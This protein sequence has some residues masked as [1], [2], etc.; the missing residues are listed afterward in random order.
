MTLQN[1]VINLSTLAN[2][3]MERKTLCC[4]LVSPKGYERVMSVGLKSAHFLE[5]KHQVIFDVIHSLGSKGL[6]IDISI[7]SDEL[8]RQNHERLFAGVHTDKISKDAHFP[9]LA[10]LSNEVA[11]AAYAEQ[12]AKVVKDDGIRR[13]L[14]NYWS[15]IYSA[16][17][18]SKSPSEIIAEGI[19]FL[20][21]AQDITARTE[22]YTMPELV[23]Y[24]KEYIIQQE[25][26]QK[27]GR[28]IT[29]GISLLDNIIGG[30]KPG[31]MIV[32]A[33]PSVGKTDLGLNFA[34]NI[35][36]RGNPVGFISA[37]MSKGEMMSRVW[38]LSLKINRLKLF[39]ATMDKHE[40]DEV[41]ADKSVSKLPIYWDFSSRPTAHT[42]RA[43]LSAMKSNYGVRV[44][45]IDH[46]QMMGWHTRHR[47]S[48]ENW[49]EIPVAL[50]EVGRDLD[51]PI[52]LLAQ[53]S[54]GIEYEKRRPRMSDLREAGEEPVD[55]CLM[56]WR[57]HYQSDDPPDV[58]EM[59]IYAVKSR[60]GKTGVVKC[61]HDMATG[62]IGQA[63]DQSR[64]PEPDEEDSPKRKYKSKQTNRVD[65]G[66]GEEDENL[67]F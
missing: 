33:R 15:V 24:S 40:K 12:Y 2:V 4:C 58:D 11:T 8:S 48:L 22:A 9:Y 18:D 13:G 27:E 45:V 26:E 29:T 19:A 55:T 67:P 63:A 14:V 3:E 20:T 31:L 17:Q 56:L 50:K 10:G 35:S 36:S 64:D 61:R 62:H 32:A 53:L 37:E 43:R 47:D 52:I 28:G 51:M 25:L 49:R 6:K 7:V 30:L 21:K 59:K 38:S 5:V 16:I 66:H 57:K 1:P 39:N 34:Q 42:I 23:D 44:A 46:L 65:T 60:N 54:R 41:W